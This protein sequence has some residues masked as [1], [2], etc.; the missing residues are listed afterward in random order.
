M[1]NY[2]EVRVKLNK[3]KLKLNKLKSA[4]KKYWHKNKNNKETFKMKNYVTNYL[5]QPN[6]ELKLSGIFL[7]NSIGMEKLGKQALMNIA[8]LWLKMFSPNL[9]LKQLQIY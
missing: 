8:F 6:K 1:A 4:A 3:L 5:L 2:E 7:G 9:Q